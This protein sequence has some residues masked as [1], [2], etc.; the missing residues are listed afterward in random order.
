MKNHLFE[1]SS[2]ALLLLLICSGITLGAEAQSGAKSD[3]VEGKSLQATS[4]AAG[5]SAQATITITANVDDSSKSSGEVGKDGEAG[6]DDDNSLS[7]QVM[8]EING[9]KHS[10]SLDGASNRLNHTFRKVIQD[11]ESSIAIVSGAFSGT[12][13]NADEIK[14]MVED[15]AGAINVEAKLPDEIKQQIDQ[16]INKLPDG[17]AINKSIEEQ[18]KNLPRMNI[19]AISSGIAIE[20]LPQEMRK[21]IKE[22]LNAANPL[23]DL[24]SLPN[25]KV[26]VRVFRMEDGKMVPVTDALNGE[27]SS[28]PKSENPAAKLESSDAKYESLNRKMDEIL[29]RLDALQSEVKALKAGE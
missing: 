26:A 28:A 2:V 22:A 6:K 24:Q 29:S 25:G 21:Q 17:D 8:I 7:G 11:G 15:A 19:E 3:T 9:K 12:E 1:T 13:L 4:E 16:V 20:K 27:G 5:N 23:G 14:K 10:F 18:L